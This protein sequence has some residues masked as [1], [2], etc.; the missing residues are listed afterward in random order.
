M[1]DMKKPDQDPDEPESFLGT[2]RDMIVD[3]D[4]RKKGEKLPVGTGGKK[5]ERKIDSIVDAME[6]GIDESKG[7]PRD[8]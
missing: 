8:Y 3:R 2:I 4:T 1:P 5:R 7:A 6:S